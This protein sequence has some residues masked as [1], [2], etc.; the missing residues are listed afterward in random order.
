MRIT[1]LLG[2]FLVSGSLVSCAANEPTVP[3]SRGAEPPVAG[4]SDA[5]G[6]QRVTFFD[7]RILSVACVSEDVRIYG[8]LIYSYSEVPSG[9]IDVEIP[10][11][12]IFVAVGM[13]TNRVFVYQNGVAP[14]RRF[15]L[16]AGGVQNVVVSEKFT[17]PDG[18]TLL[19][20]TRN[21]PLTVNP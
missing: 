9:G 2:L 16:A 6:W 10:K 19:E 13:K 11:A 7:D 20:A 15:H 4:S 3:L 1:R 5:P 18:P 12:P 21:L 8:F 17:A 14:I